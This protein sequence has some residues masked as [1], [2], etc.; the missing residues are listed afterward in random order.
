MDIKSFERGFPSKY[1]GLDKFS[2]PKHLN[3]RNG[4]V[5]NQAWNVIV[6]RARPFSFCKGHFQKGHFLK[7]MGNC[8][9]ATKDKSRATEA[10]AS[11]PSVWLQACF[12]TWPGPF[13]FETA[14]ED[15][16]AYSYMYVPL[17]LLFHS[18][19]VTYHSM[20]VVNDKLMP[21]FFRT[22]NPIVMT[23]RKMIQSSNH[24]STETTEDRLDKDTNRMICVRL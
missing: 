14:V 10:M 16:A 1:Y 21:L 20:A 22:A 8:W 24:N 12:I 19:L 2:P 23:M 15:I 11:V 17:L 18:G 6:E 9:M 13:R 7:S 4:G 3:L 5:L